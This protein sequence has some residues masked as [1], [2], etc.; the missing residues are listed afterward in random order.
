VPRRFREQFAD[1]ERDQGVQAWPYEERF[2]PISWIRDRSIEFLD[3]HANDDAPFCLVASF[4]YPHAPYNPAERFAA[5]YDP[6]DVEVPTDHWL[7]MAGMPPRLR[8]FD[9]SGWYPR[10][11]FPEPLLR[12]LIA[13]YH[14]LVSQID[15]A[16]AGLMRHVD[17]SN[18]L[19]VFTSDHGDYLGHRGRVGK[20]PWIPVEDLALVP[21]FAVGAGVP[22]GRVVE[23]PVAHVDLAATFLAAAGIE[24]PP[25]LNGAPLQRYFS[26]P[27]FGADRAIHCRGDL[28]M[29]RRGSLK[30]FRGE[31]G[32]DEM[33][34]D[35][36]NDPGELVN[37]ASQPERRSE[38]AALASEMQRV[39]GAPRDSSR[40]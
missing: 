9:K 29:T 2:H 3:A 19:V 18:T 33:L 16:I 15:D 30:Y 23:S 31:S 27:D 37:L 4:R 26:D 10:D 8:A 28:L 35:L 39:Y 25:A 34:F 40:A 17:T 1:F 6:A 21:F 32:G 7:D 36:A 13:Y 14:A 20:S 11:A 22:G 5:L 12:R 38:I 24:A